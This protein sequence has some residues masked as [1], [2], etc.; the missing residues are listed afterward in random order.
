MWLNH[1]HGHP[2]N[3]KK[4][5][6]QARM[7]IHEAVG[8]FIDN[9]VDEKSTGPTENQLSRDHVKNAYENSAKEWFDWFWSRY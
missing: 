5:Y 4:T 8:K 9:T 2:Y 1:H 6:K 3:A 7:I